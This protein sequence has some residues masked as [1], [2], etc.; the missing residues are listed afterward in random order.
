MRLLNGAM[1]AR[2]ESVTRPFSYRAEG[3]DDQSMEWIR[4]EVVEPPRLE[5]LKLALHPPAYTG[6]PA[7]TSEKSDSSHARYA[8]RQWRA[9][10]PKSFAR[11][12]SARKAASSRQRR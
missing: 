1:V 12:P 10:R 9:R 2:K 11:R 7:E 3:G 5:S 6:L 8:R 4:L